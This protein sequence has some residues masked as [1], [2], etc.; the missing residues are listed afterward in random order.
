MLLRELSQVGGLLLSASKLTE[1]YPKGF[2]P[3]ACSLFFC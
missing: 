2:I 3:E 1:C